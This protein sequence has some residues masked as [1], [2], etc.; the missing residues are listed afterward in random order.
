MSEM[1]LELFFMTPY[2]QGWH[3]LKMMKSEG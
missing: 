2:E 1:R 3:K